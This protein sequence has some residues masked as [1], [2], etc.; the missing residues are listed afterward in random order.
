MINKKFVTIVVLLALGLILSTDC[1]MSQQSSKLQRTGFEIGGSDLGSNLSRGSETSGYT[2]KESPGNLVGSS[3]A[4]AFLPEPA[5]PSNIPDDTG[6][7]DWV[8]II[9]YAPSHPYPYKAEIRCYG[10]YEDGD[11]QGIIYLYPD[12]SELPKN[13]IIEFQGKP[14][15]AVNFY[16]SQL[17][18]ILTLLN[19]KDSALAIDPNDTNWG[20]II[21][22]LDLR[23]P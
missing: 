8:D 12:G 2:V 23:S 3:H 5:G 22:S 16:M 10:S 19:T 17:N 7:I 13:A 15:I 1:V 14:T 6:H 18:D 20:R 11:Q 21:A 9:Y 4:G